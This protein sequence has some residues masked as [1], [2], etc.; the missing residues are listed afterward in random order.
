MGNKDSFKC[1]KNYLFKYK[2]IYFSLHSIEEERNEQLFIKDYAKAVIKILNS[3][4]V[5]KASFVCHSFGGRVLFKIHEINPYLIDKIILYD[6]AGLKPKKTLNK[7]IKIIKYKISKF[8]G[9]KNLDKFF[10]SDY[11]AMDVRHRQTFKNIVNEHF[12]NYVSN[13]KNPS[14]IVYG[15]EDKDTPIYMAKK[16]NK[17]LINSKLEIFEN[18]GHFCYLQNNHALLLAQF[19]LNC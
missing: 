4:N 5:E 9:L 7:S 8:L 10:S 18:C 15:K 3:L 6:V 19:F 16:L 2:Q 1:F 12:D 11:K 17:K 14:L 13:I